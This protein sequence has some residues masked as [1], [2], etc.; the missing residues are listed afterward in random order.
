M[1]WFWLIVVAIIII[2]GAWFLFT[3]DAMAP[4]GD[5]VDVS[6]DS[7]GVFTTDMAPMAETVA[8]N[9]SDFTPKDVVVKK[10]GTVT[11]VNQGGEKMWVASA[12]HPTHEVYDGTVRETHCPN[13]SNTAFD[14]CV[15]EEGDYSF[16]F[17]KVG[18]WNYHDHLMPGATGRV[19]VVE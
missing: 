5:G 13:V 2:A 10:G 9:G 8:Y 15:G 17:D 19:M 6:A 11:F 1:K 12:M 4:A 18:N 14:Q 3:D 7:N 16:T